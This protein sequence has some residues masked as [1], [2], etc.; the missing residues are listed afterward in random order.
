MNAGMNEGAALHK[1]STHAHMTVYFSEAARCRI[2]LE[3]LE[4]QTQQRWRAR[5]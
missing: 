4:V 2:M 1:A 5:D 3:A